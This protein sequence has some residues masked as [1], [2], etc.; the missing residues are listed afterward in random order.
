M[1]LIINLGENLNDTS[2]FESYIDY[3]DLEGKN[4][5]RETNKL[6]GNQPLNIVKS[7]YRKDKK[8]L[9][10]L[11]STLKSLPILNEYKITINK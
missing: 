7:F 6:V 11:I 9:Y 3:Y 2:E 10:V 8:K 4:I 5:H 1:N